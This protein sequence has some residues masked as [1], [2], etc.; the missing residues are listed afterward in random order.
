MSTDR[1]SLCRLR[2]EFVFTPTAGLLHE[3]GS[4][5][6]VGPSCRAQRKAQRNANGGG[7]ASEGGYSSVVVRSPVVLRVAG[8][9]AADAATPIARHARCSRR[10]ARA[11]ATSPGSPSGRR[12][13]SPSTARTASPSAAP[14]PPAACPLAAPLRT[15]TPAG[16]P[17]GV[18][19]S[20]CQ[21]ERRAWERRRP[22][23]ISRSALSPRRP[24]PVV[25]RCRHR[26][27]WARNVRLPGPEAA[28]RPPR[29]V[30]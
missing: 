19:A 22:C 29:A 24:L 28:W 2:Q 23:V 5:T 30:P 21:G 11:V 14:A 17:A 9:V 4:A 6:R 12:A 8:T 26:P 18:S 1:S 15:T 27:W 7:Y 3:R 10:P 16:Y 20:S 25:P 13:A